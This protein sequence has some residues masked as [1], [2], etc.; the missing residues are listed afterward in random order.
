[1]IDITSGLIKKLGEAFPGAYINMHEEFIVDIDKN[2][3]FILS[4]CETEDD[5]KAKVLEWLSSWA[6][7]AEPY[8]KEGLNQKLHADLQF[9]INRYLG[10]HFT[11]DEFLKIYIALGNRINHELTMKFIKSNFDLKVLSNGE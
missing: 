9:K 7:K 1:M 3:Y 8:R 4:D 10:T 5:I 2:I 11:A 6:S